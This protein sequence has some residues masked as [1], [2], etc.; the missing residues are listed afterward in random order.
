MNYRGAFGLQWKILAVQLL[1]G[2]A[3]AA[4]V[5]GGYL[6]AGVA[7]A[8]PAQAWGVAAAAGLAALGS[9]AWI[10]FRLLHAMKLRMWDAADMAER[11]SRG[12]YSV[13][14]RSLHDDELAML[15]GELDAMAENLTQAV[16]RLRGLSEQNRRLAEEAGRGAALEE[17]AQLAR[18]LHDTVNQQLFALAMRIAAAAKRAAASDP[19]G[20]AEL[21]QLEELARGAHTETRALI[22]QLRP[23]TLEQQ[24]IGSALQEYARGIAS[25]E[26]WEFIDEIDPAVTLRDEQGM[27][28]F[29]IAQETLHN[30]QK[31]AGAHTVWV[32][33]SQREGT[34]TLQIRDDGR[35][36]DAT[37][38]V[39][40]TAVGLVGI[41]ERA[42]ALGGQFRIRTAPGEGTEISVTLPLSPESER[43]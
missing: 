28:L 32:K 42:L 30:V 17:R 2:L 11:I 23:T 8:D 29:R 37:S 20:A 10:V 35:G 36:F 15:E 1:T 14:L 3:V 22:L 26:G 9:G 34:I 19:Q 33:L 24:G 6:L 5:A 16:S 40:A 27:H 12:D 43:Q 4:G 39:R 31:H 38:G 41:Q 13:R 21:Q 18:E 25:R 7:G